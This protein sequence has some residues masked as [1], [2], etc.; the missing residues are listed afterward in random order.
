MDLNDELIKDIC[1]CGQLKQLN[2]GKAVFC[3]EAKGNNPP[4]SI[5]F[6]SINKGEVCVATT[7][8]QTGHNAYDSLID[9]EDMKTCSYRQTK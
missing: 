7:F 1:S 4:S 2:R 9:I 8:Y 6:M 3:E 5:Q